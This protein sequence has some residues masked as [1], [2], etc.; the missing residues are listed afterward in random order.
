MSEISN[1]IIICELCEITDSSVE[2][3]T[4]EMID[5]RKRLEE[6]YREKC[7]RETPPQAENPRIRKWQHRLY[8]EGKKL[9]HIEEFRD[10][11]GTL[12]P[13]RVIKC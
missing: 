9:S 4:S 11:H 7:K 5:A 10:E 6:F 8:Y 2:R 1:G 3:R 13:N 12:I